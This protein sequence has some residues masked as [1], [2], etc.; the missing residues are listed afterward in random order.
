MFGPSEGLSGWAVR[1]NAERRTPAY[2][3]NAS[4]LVQCFISRGRNVLGKQLGT[5]DKSLLES[6][7]LKDRKEDGRV[8]LRQCWGNRFPLESS[9]NK[10]LPVI[11][12]LFCSWVVSCLVL[13]AWRHRDF[14]NFYFQLYIRGGVFT[15][16]RSRVRA[17]SEDLC[18]FCLNVSHISTGFSFLSYRKWWGP[19]T[20]AV[21]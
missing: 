14:K 15:G 6:N 1:G 9:Q 10:R 8:T 16:F 7:R 18:L 4:H 17:L 19:C 21:S 5:G 20:V 13:L 3:T 11:T 2:V 12:P